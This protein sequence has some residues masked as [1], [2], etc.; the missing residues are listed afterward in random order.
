MFDKQLNLVGPGP[1]LSP[2]LK[3]YLEQS[4]VSQLQCLYH[5]CTVWLNK[6]SVTIM[7]SMLP[8]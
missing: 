3:L 7:G 8:L 2:Q 4:T 1:R 6:G 5:V